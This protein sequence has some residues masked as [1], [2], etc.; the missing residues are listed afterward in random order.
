[1]RKASAW[2]IGRHEGVGFSRHSAKE[3]PF[4][5]G[6]KAGGADV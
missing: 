4:E 2:L 1:M 6:F 5:I 3:R